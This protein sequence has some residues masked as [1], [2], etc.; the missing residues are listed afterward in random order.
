LIQSQPHW[1]WRAVDLD[2]YV[3][4]EILQTRRKMITDKLKSYGTASES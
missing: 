1:L 3:L 2:G 4:D